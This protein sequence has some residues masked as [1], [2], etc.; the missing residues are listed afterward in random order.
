MLTDLEIQQLP[1]PTRPEAAR[2]LAQATMGFNISDLNFLVANG[3]WVW[4]ETQF[5]IPIT[6]QPSHYDW[7]MAK[8]A[9]LDRDGASIFNRSAYRAAVEGRDQLRQRMTYALSQILVVSGT[10]NQ[11]LPYYYYALAGYYDLL[12]Q[13]AFG[14]YGNLLFEV[15]RTLIMANFLTFL[16]SSKQ[17][18]TTSPDENYAREIQQLFTIGVNSLA[19]SNS[20]PVVPSQSV[21]GATVDAYDIG[22]IRELAKVFTGWSLSR[23]FVNP[24]DQKAGS[25]G[26]Q[27][28][29]ANHD[30]SAIVLEYPLY[31]S[32]GDKLPSHFITIPAGSDGLARKK[33]AVLG[34]VAHPNT[35]AYI[36][37]QLIQRMVTSNPSSDY[38]TRVA[39]VFR[40]EA[41]G[42]LKNVLKAILFDKSLFVGTRRTAGLDAS[43]REFGKVREPYL[44]LTQWGRLFGAQSVSAKWDIGDI[45]RRERFNQAPLMAPN[46]FNFYRP[47]YVPPSSV[48]ARLTKTRSDTKYKEPIVAPEFQITNEYTTLTYMGALYEAM[49]PDRG[50]SGTRDVISNYSGW[51]SKASNPAAL[52]DELNTMLAA[53]R[54][55][56][57]AIASIVQAVGTMAGGNEVERRLRVQTAALLIMISPE[58]IV[59][60]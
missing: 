15:S 6:E 37:R 24:R 4:L 29:P 17:V 8:Y 19:R 43:D 32:A 45:Y 52:V 59:Q 23:G 9:Y 27:F 30:Q 13:N 26:L 18:G 60:K 47:G 49:D 22:H 31:N 53:G 50:V 3:Y 7:L 39:N 34:L 16:G 25:H 10:T 46:V 42:N 55:N 1:K 35:G 38:V 2:F 54:I 56:A 12:G 14:N 58:Y 20:L 5:S 33:T 40:Q 36:S 41:G 11:V 57:T 51:T 28:T 44:R 21:T 48:A